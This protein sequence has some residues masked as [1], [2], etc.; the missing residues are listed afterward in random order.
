[1][2]RPL[3][4][5][6]ISDNL[7]EVL[8]VLALKIKQNIRTLSENIKFIVRALETGKRSEPLTNIVYILFNK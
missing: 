7:A 5:L 2:E 8:G 6:L 3:F 4:L 1:L